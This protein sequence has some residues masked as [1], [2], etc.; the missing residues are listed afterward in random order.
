MVSNRCK[1]IG[2]GI[3]IRL[4]QRRTKRVPSRTKSLGISAS[5]W[6]VSDIVGM[7][8]GEREWKGK[9]K[10]R[11]AILASFRGFGAARNN[12]PPSS[13]SSGASFS[14]FHLE[15][16]SKQLTYPL[17]PLFS[18]C[19]WHHFLCIPDFQLCTPSP[20]K[21]SL[22]I[23]RIVVSALW[24]LCLILIRHASELPDSPRARCWDSF[25]LAN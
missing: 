17:F 12:Y 21:Y 1:G 8:I 13:L 10:A 24:P 5:S 3:D 9:E 20:G 18:A 7:G 4:V 15:S 2:I 22:R 23:V 25:L 19:L 14:P 16:P 6:K 11:E